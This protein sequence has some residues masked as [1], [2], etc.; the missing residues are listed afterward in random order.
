MPN[1]SHGRET[2]L[3]LKRFFDAFYNAF[4]PAVRSV[5]HGGC[6]QGGMKNSAKGIEDFVPVRIDVIVADRLPEVRPVIE[7]RSA[8][9]ALTRFLVVTVKSRLIPCEEKV[10]VLR[11]RKF[12]TIPGGF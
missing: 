9:G 10:H 1:E 7:A 3:T 11:D 5:E 4:A 6:R 8:V 2:D 12:E